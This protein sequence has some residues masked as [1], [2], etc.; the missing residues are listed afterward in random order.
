MVNLI[1]YLNSHEFSEESGESI[2]THSKFQNFILQSHLNDNIKGG[3][4]GLKFVD[5]ASSFISEVALQYSVETIL[6]IG[7][8]PGLYSKILA[9]KGFELT[10]IDVSKVSIDFAKKNAANAQLDINYI[11]DDIKTCEIRNKFDMAMIL[12]Q[13]YSTF[14]LEDRTKILKKI[15]NSLNEEGLL[16][17]D[18]PSVSLYQKLIDINLWETNKEYDEI[19]NDNLLILTKHQKYKN[20][21]MLNK[22]I[23]Y[24]KQDGI[25]DFNEWYQHFSLTTIKNELDLVGFKT[26][27]VYSD[28]DGSDYQDGANC[29]TI[30]CKKSI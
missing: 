27:A 5:L 23:Y 4:R 8:G 18:V 3:G 16:L 10:G 19:F 30:L 21:L 14:T 2:W 11:N 7:C 24:F 29:I 1:D 17:L 6:D 12:Y 25:Y 26:I 22:A 15:Y 20:N 9:E 28:V 13:T